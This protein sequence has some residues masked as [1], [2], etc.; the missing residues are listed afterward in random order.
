MPSVFSAGVPCAVARFHSP[1]K[2]K[3]NGTQITRYPHKD[4]AIRI[5]L[6]FTILL[7]APHLWVDPHRADTLKAFT[8]WLFRQLLILCGSHPHINLRFIL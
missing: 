7:T 2:Q 3:G 5:P 1:P 8:L 6:P 4:I